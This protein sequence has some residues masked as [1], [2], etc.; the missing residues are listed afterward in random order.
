MVSQQFLPY[1]ERVAF[2]P[3]CSPRTAAVVVPKLVLSIQNTLP[4]DAERSFNFFLRRIK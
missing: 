1:A 3:L 4:K 2:D